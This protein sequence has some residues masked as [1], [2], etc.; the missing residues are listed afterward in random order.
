MRCPWPIFTT[1]NYGFWTLRIWKTCCASLAY[2]APPYLPYSAVAVDKFLVSAW[3][4][5]SLRELS[6]AFDLGR[7]YLKTAVFLN[8]RNA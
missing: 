6:G 8:G 2:L 3:S 5:K 4:L 7:S 1:L